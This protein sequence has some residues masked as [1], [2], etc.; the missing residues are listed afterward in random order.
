MPETF[1]IADTHFGHTNILRFEAAH[2]PF[3]T[4][5]EM[6]E[7]LVDNWN[8]TVG[9]R[10]TVWHLGDVLF[11]SGEKLEIIGRLNGRK[12]LVMG[13]HDK[14]GAAVYLR[15]FRKVEALWKFDGCLLSHIP[16]HPSQFYRYQAN[17][18]GHLHSRHVR[19][20]QDQP[21]PRYINVSCEQWALKPVPYSTIQQLLNE[22]GL[23]E[24]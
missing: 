10:D 21:D 12:N 24:R 19:D 16:V 9:H 13:N 22:A 7:A 4:V 5:E 15:H 8:A 20:G 11:G 2:R 14:H 6:N 18:H 23:G 17:I 3:A 1:F